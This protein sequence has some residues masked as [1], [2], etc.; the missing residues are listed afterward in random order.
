[1]EWYKLKMAGL[2]S[3]RIRFLMGKYESYTELIN[4]TPEK[5]RA[6]LETGE[7]FNLIQ[8]SK[9][10]EAFNN[11]I[12]HLKERGIGLISLN[13]KEYSKLLKEIEKPPLFLFY[14]GDISLLNRD[15]VISIVGTRSSTKYG[16]NALKNIM[17]ELLEAKVTVVSGLA[18]GIDCLAHKECLKGKGDTIAVLSCGIDVFYPEAT[19]KERL[20][21]E[22][23]GLVVSEFPLGTKV[24]KGSFP[25]RNRIIAGLSKGTLIVESGERGGGLITTELA[26][27]EGRDVF[28]I[29]GDI[30]S[31]KSKG[32]NK[33]IRDSRA[34]LI[35]SG[36]DIL[37][38]YGWEKVFTI[39]KEDKRLFGEKSKIFNILK[40]KMNLEE[41]KK[42]IHLPTGE[43]LSYLMELELEGFIQSL[44][45]GCYRRK[46]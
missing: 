7:E 37:I 6:I 16:E 28:A 14:K 32:C 11:F 17:K 35:L 23:V 45:G 34:K 15:R 8:A 12:E 20:E 33:L 41:I 40:I 31:P 44:P 1:M 19:I 18:A 26:L 3:S 22:K 46:N 39:E 24:T 25:V 9:N 42:E 29:P 38:E 21:I 2:K 30:F 43:L 4:E 36:S 10:I 27:E 5:L 13:S